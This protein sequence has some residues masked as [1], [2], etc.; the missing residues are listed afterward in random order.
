M[1]NDDTDTVTDRPTVTARDVRAWRGQPG[2]TVVDV[3]PIAAYNGW[4][5]QGEAR[6]GHIA[7]AVSFPRAWLT[8]I[9]EPEIQRL[10]DAKGITRDRTIVVYGDDAEDA[11][12]L[13]ARLDAAGYPDVWRYDAGFSAW[14]ADDSLPVERLPHYQRRVDTDWVRELIEGGE[15]ATYDGRGFRLFHVNF[16]RPRGIRGRSPARCAV[17]GHEPPGGSGHLEPTFPG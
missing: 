13:T 2:V 16:G 12:G 14:A 11:G 9:D 15:P 5:L 17:P 8:S 10:L 3:R 4:R 7:S 1:S 6:G